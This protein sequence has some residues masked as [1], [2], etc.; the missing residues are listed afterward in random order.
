MLTIS[1]LGIT[2]ESDLVVKTDEYSSQ[3]E[4][5]DCT[6]VYCAVH[7]GALYMDDNIKPN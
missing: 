6:S 7:I 1:T 4:T 2:R 3:G 5:T